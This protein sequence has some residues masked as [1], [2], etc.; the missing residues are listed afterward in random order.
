MNYTSDWSRP[1]VFYDG[2]CSLCSRE[3]AHY[4]K[5]DKR[6]Q[7]GWV[8]VNTDT[9]MLD[10][11]PLTRAQAMKRMHVLESDGTLVSGAAAFVAMWQRLPPYRPLAWLVSLPGVFR[12]TE[13]TYNRFAR[14]R[15]RRRCGESCGIE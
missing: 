8:D 7:L 12:L 9:D 3:I 11:F 13:W 6:G 4:R 14:W 2:G 5:I 10:A 15:W 1:V